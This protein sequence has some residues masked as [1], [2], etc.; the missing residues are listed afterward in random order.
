MEILEKSWIMIQHAQNPTQPPQP[1]Y[2][3]T[4]AIGSITQKHSLYRLPIA[5]LDT[6]DRICGIAQ[7]VGYTGKQDNDLTIYRLK[8]KTGNNLP[9]MTLPGFYVLEQGIFV[10]YEQWCMNQRVK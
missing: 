4:I 2:I 3:P 6:P 8:I 7:R 5:T 9:V 1:T 10:D